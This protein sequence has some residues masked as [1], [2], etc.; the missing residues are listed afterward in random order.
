LLAIAKAATKCKPRKGRGPKPNFYQ[1]AIGPFSATYSTAP[2]GP[3]SATPEAFQVVAV[4]GS[5]D[6]LDASGQKRRDESQSE[7]NGLAA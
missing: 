2:I 3:F 6:A 7:P 1:L 4:E 5:E